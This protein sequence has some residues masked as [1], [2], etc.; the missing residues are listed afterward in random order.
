MAVKLFL[1]GLTPETTRQ[2]IEA[3]FRKFGGVVDS[4]VMYKGKTS[5]GFG[6][7]SFTNIAIA[8]KVCASG[9]H[10]L[11][12]RVVDVK[13]AV[14]KEHVQSNKVFVGGLPH[15]CEMQ[16]ILDYFSKYGTIVDGSIQ[17]DRRTN[18]SRGFAFVRFLRSSSVE[19]VMKHR[20]QHQIG[21]KWVDVKR[22]I[23]EGEVNT[24]SPAPKPPRAENRLAGPT[25]KET[26]G[27][28][29]RVAERAEPT[30][31]QHAAQQFAQELALVHQMAMFEAQA[32]AE[33]RL[34]MEARAMAAHWAGVQAGRQEEKQRTAARVCPKISAPPGLEIYEDDIC[35]DRTCASPTGRSPLAPRNHRAVE[36]VKDSPAQGWAWETTICAERD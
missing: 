8:E 16:I 20:D 7:V 1:G 5:R 12:G 24:T 31:A 34:C 10:V 33:A 9:P 26:Q 3:Y 28:P 17:R 22:A 36:R 21:G 13:F 4:A 35:R 14:A 29:A 27:G 30:A 25:N 2:Q 15:D 6:F 32:R 18:R 19:L 11:D 23:A